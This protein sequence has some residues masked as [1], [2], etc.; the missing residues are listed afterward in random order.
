MLF[1]R[2]N[3]PDLH[4]CYRSA[5]VL[6]NYATGSPSLGSFTIPYFDLKLDLTPGQITALAYATYFVVLEPVAGVSAR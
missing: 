1:K 4:V 3:L 5:Q 2:T 6:V